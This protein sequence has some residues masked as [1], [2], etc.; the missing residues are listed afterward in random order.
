VRKVDG[1][2][3]VSVTDRGIGIPQEELEK[4]F[5]VF[6]RSPDAGRA[7]SA[8]WGSSLHQQGDRR[9]PRCELA[10]ESA[11]G[12]GSTFTMKLPRRRSPIHAQPESPEPAAAAR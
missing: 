8:A 12:K 7:T 6:Y 5:G 4:I 11:P 9:S 10:V 3:A 2:A 1:G